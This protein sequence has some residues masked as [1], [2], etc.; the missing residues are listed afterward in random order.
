MRFCE[1]LAE[2][3]LVTVACRAVGKHR[4]TIYAHLRTDAL[5][6]AA[7]D[8]ARFQARYRLADRLLE[9]LIEGSVDHFY[10]DGVLVGERRF[11]D[12]R[13]AYAMLRRLDKIAEGQGKPA[14]DGGR[15][16]DAKLALKAL[17]TGAE[18]DLCAALAI[19]VPTHPT[20]PDLTTTMSAM[21]RINFRLGPRVAG[22]RRFWWTDFPPPEGFIGEEQG[23]WG[24]D[25]YA[26]ECSDD[27][28]D[29]LEAARAAELSELR[30]DEEAERNTF[31]AELQEHL[32][33]RKTNL[34]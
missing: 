25:D 14:R 20:T 12:N 5:F 19:S 8:S 23:R 4:D 28:C 3:G 31:F 7:C 22:R 29:V 6:S 18:E 24:D 27:E 9:D 30:A 16:F 13:L 1:A 10:R 17:Q 33:P 15:K 34:G 11:T 26:R 21:C 2:T 32:Q